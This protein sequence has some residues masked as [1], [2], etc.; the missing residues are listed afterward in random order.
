MEKEVRTSH[1]TPRRCP[2]CERSDLL[3]EIG[4]RTVNVHQRSRTF[5]WR[6]VDSVC[7]GCGLLQ[8]LEAP[9][10]DFLNDYYGDAHTTRTSVGDAVVTPGFDV[11]ARLSPIRRWHRGGRI[12]E[13]GAGD[14]AFCAALQREGY[15]A[16]GVDPLEDAASE[17]VVTG[18]ATTGSLGAGSA[19]TVVAYDVLEHA[20]DP[21][22]WIQSALSLLEPEGLLI[23]E[24]PDAETWPVE[25]WHHEH[26]TQFTKD[27]L[28]R[29]CEQAG[30]ETVSCGVEPPSRPHGITYVGR[31]GAGR[32]IQ[33]NVAERPNAE[34]IA[35]ARQLYARA[36]R[37]RIRQRQ[38]AA[39]TA[40]AVIAELPADPGQRC[41]VIVWGANE[42]ASAIG[43]ALV[44]SGVDVMVRIVDNAD[45]KIGVPHPGFRTPVERPHFEAVE[46]TQFVFVLCSRVW[47]DHIAAQIRGMGLPSWTIVDG[48]NWPAD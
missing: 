22:D 16:V 37:I 14:G 47:N 13:I 10:P 39:Q 25:A 43:A 26:L 21:L 11:S 20:A 19:S 6:Q 2:I 29:L 48:T 27:S 23:L 17:L 9:E 42:I 5:Q 33:G 34:A 30:V 24:V 28:R 4:R 31:A 40:D 36:E 45:S 12:L 38:A 18:Y 35:H 7:S 1:W 32:Q 3:V 15:D 44:D 46:A 41:E 8:G